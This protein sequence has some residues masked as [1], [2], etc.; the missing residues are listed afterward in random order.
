MGDKFGEV[1]IDNLHNRGCSLDGVEHCRTLETQYARW[2]LKYFSY[3]SN[4]FL[5][6]LEHESASTTWQGLPLSIICTSYV[7]DPHFNT[8]VLCCWLHFGPQNLCYI[9]VPV[10]YINCMFWVCVVFSWGLAQSFASVV[11]VYYSLMLPYHSLFFDVI[12]PLPWLWCYPALCLWFIR[13]CGLIK[14]TY[15]PWQTL[16]TSFPLYLFNGIQNYIALQILCICH[17]FQVA[18]I[19]QLGPVIKK[20]EPLMFITWTRPVWTKNNRLITVVTIL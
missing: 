2:L 14:L 3:M 5:E 13:D 10:Y 6:S 11:F 1:M 20:M 9:E 7:L 8:T 15:L 18:V 17:I 16:N 4:K 19:S 12:I